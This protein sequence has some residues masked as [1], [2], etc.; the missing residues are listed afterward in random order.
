[1]KMVGVLMLADFAAMGSQGTERPR[2]HSYGEGYILDRLMNKE[3]S[4]HKPTKALHRSISR[5]IRRRST[6][7][8]VT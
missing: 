8:C 4:R 2:P 1:M 7:Y 5:S 6:F 3:N